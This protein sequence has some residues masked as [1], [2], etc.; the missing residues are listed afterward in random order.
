MTA[1]DFNELINSVHAST[2]V[3]QLPNGR[4]GGAG[5]SRQLDVHEGQIWAVFVPPVSRTAHRQ[6]ADIPWQKSGDPHTRSGSH[7]AGLRHSKL[8]A[9]TVRH[10]LPS[11][12]HFSFVNPFSGLRPQAKFRWCHSVQREK[13]WTECLPKVATFLLRLPIFSRALDSDFLVQFGE[14]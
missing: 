12:R 7:G 1:V 4:R 2:G 8:L 10:L 3:S 6:H 13:L 11:L 9:V 5:D 14:G